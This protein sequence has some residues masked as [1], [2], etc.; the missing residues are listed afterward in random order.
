MFRNGS[1]PGLRRPV[2]SDVVA[3]RQIEL[4]DDTETESEDSDVEKVT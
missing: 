3:A 2:T 1:V 4:D